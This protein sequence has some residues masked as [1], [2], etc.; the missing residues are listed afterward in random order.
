MNPNAETT[1]DQGILTDLIHF[2]WMVARVIAVA[3]PG[4][5]F[6]GGQD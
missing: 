3:E 2:R 4:F 6:R 1:L 5:Q